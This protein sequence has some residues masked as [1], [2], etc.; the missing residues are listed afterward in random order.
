MKITPKWKVYNHQKCHGN[1]PIPRKQL[2]GRKSVIPHIVVVHNTCNNSYI[3][4]EIVLKNVF[5]KFG[6][7]VKNKVNRKQAALREIQYD[8]FD[9]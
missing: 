1:F 2:F 5:A 4:E 3:S 8:T 7:S 6:L 9:L